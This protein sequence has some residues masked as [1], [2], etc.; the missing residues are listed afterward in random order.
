M[1]SEPLILGFDTSAAHCAAAL[2]SGDR[3]LAA[4]TEQMDRGQAERLMPLLQEVLTEGG[5]G[6][7]DLDTIGVGI[8]P[9]NFTG[10]RISVAAA[11]GLALA[12][13]IPAVGVSTLDAMALDAGF[14]VTAI[15]APADM[16]YSQC[17]GGATVLSA[18]ED[19]P[20]PPARAEACVIGYRADEIA[21]RTGGCP[22]APRY[23]LAEAIARKAKRRRHNDHLVA[24]APLYI[25]A[26][27]AAPMREA[28]PVILDA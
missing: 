10:I 13:E 18:L 16:L 23:P 8:G 3:V 24:P 25:R 14:V 2:L 20:L 26:A 21:A 5:A 7:R 9:G 17:P 22:A 6:W 4:R 27:D 1:G 15:R 28:P 11:R 19:M 12:L